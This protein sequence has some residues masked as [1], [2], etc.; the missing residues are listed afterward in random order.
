MSDLQN[1]LIKHLRLL[2]HPEGGYFS[3]T[4]RSVHIL[5]KEHLQDIYS[6]DRNYFT[7]ILYLLNDSNFSSFHRLKSDELWHFYF[8]NSLVLNTISPDGSYK[9]VI[10]GNDFLNGERFQ[11]LVPAHYWMSASVKNESGFSLVGC[12]LA[13]GFHFEDFELATRKNLIELFPV[14]R[15]IIEKYTR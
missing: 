3:E 14:H 13:P 6:G 12:T 9:S 15:V 11:Y 4:Y 2:P 8:G 7:A 5:K 10:L 1:N